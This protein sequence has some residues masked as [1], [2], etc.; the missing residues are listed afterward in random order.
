MFAS[1]LAADLIDSRV[2]KRAS[3][4]KGGDGDADVFKTDKH[5]AT[6]GL[7]HGGKKTGFKSK[8]KYKRKKR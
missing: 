2:S 8:T 7:R 5:L 6:G 1:D 3:K 4:K